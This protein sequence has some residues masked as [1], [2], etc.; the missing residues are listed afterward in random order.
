MINK[1]CYK[2][3]VKEFDSNSVHYSRAVMLDKLRLMNYFFIENGVVDWWKN[4]STLKMIKTKKELGH[5]VDVP[6]SNP[7]GFGLVGLFNG[8]STFAGYLMTKPFSL[9]NSSGNI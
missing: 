1:K 8:I 2:A 4:A 3:I 9:K 5:G 7:R 6:S